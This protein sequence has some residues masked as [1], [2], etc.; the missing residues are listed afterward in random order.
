MPVK[1]RSFEAKAMR[2]KPGSSVTTQD[3]Q[4]PFKE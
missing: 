4:R 2:F 1:E 3:G